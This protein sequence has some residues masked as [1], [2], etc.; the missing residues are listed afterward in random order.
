VYVDFDHAADFSHFRTYAWGGAPN[1]NAIADLPLMQS[2]QRDIDSQ[3]TTKGLKRIQEFQYPD[4]IVLASAGMKRR[5]V[6]NM[7]T[8]G[9]V[10]Q[11]RLEEIIP[12]TFDTGA[13]VVDIYNARRQQMVWQGIP[14]NMLSSTQS[15]N[16]HEMY[17]VI[18]R[19][20]NQYP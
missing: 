10:W 18:A 5:T 2:T 11:R 9:C 19:M 13:L 17:K 20:F 14:K 7:G 6:Y 16:D 4:L 8:C 15:R 3:L 12:A 1:P